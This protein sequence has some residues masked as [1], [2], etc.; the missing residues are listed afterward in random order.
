MTYQVVANGLTVV[1]QGY[2]MRVENVSTH[3]DAP[4]DLGYERCRIVRFTGRCT[5]NP[6][7]DDIRN[8]AY[9]GGTYGGNYLAG[10][11]F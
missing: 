9:N 1:V 5:D 3:L 6:V 2:L 7:N 10:Y 11:A 8:S 4:N